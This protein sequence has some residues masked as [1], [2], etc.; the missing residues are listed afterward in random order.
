MCHCV[1][2]QGP[3]LH[4]MANSH[5]RRRRD[6]TVELRRRRRC[7]HNSQLAHNHCRSTI[8][9]DRTGLTIREF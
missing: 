4:L 3:L 1:M 7:E 5:R 8:E 9:T 2:T 6:S